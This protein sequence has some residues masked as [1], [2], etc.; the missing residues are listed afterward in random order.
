MLVRSNVAIQHRYRYY[1][2]RDLASDLDNMS[3]IVFIAVKIQTLQVEGCQ[4]FRNRKA[5]YY[6]RHFTI[7]RTITVY[8]YTFILIYTEHDIDCRITTSGSN[9]IRRF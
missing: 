9:F 3:D 1:I 4:T 7:I 6:S 5:P 8:T 2:C